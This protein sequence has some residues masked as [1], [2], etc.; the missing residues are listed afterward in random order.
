M[1]VH[2]E[3]L[4]ELIFCPTPPNFGVEAHIEAPTG[5]ALRKIMAC[6]EVGPPNSLGSLSSHDQLA[7]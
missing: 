5:V 2:M 7:R 6:I 4:L 1:E 3:A